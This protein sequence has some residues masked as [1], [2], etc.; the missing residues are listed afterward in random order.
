VFP[1]QFLP[2]ALLAAAGVATALYLLRSGMVRRGLLLLATV[3]VAADVAVVARFV[4]GERATW[5]LGGLWT[6]QLASL[7]AAVWLVLA[8]LRRRW[9]ADA[10]RRRELFAAAFQHYLRDEFGPAR[11]LLRRILRADPWDVAAS[12]ALADVR[13]RQGQP[14]RA[15]R[16]LRRARRLDRPMAYADFAAEQVRRIR[17]DLAPRP[18]GTQAQEAR[19]RPS[20]AP[21]AQSPPAQPRPD[22]TSRQEPP[23]PSAAVAAS[24]SLPPEAR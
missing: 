1:D 10:R 11:S 23:P 17:T 12:I 20:Q 21:P 8:L 5:F 14:V 18:P 2:S 16:L 19:A 22:R 6:L 13:W 9:S 4:F 24:K 7:G 15:L 3:A